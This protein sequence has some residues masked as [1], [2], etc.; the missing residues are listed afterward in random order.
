M[1][2]SL[3]NLF[4][5]LGS[6]LLVAACGGDHAGG[7]ETG[8]NGNSGQ[9][10]PVANAGTTQSVAAGSTVTLD[11]S[12]S[13][14]PSGTLGYQW[15]LV[16]KPAE[17]TAELQGATSAR[18]SFVADKVGRYEADLV[19]SNGSASSDHARVVVM[20]G[21][22]DP[23]ADG[24]TTLM[25]ELVD[26]WVQLD[27]SYS[28]PPAGGDPSGL[29]YQW[30]VTDPKGAAVQLFDSKSARP[31]F[32]PATD[33]LYLAKL[34][35]LYGARSS[36]EFVISVNVTKA[37]TQPVSHVGG[38]NGKYAGV[39]G[40][41]VQLDGSQSSDADGDAL[42]YTWTLV[43]YPDINNGKYMPYS[44]ARLENAD[45]A[46][47]TFHADRAGIYSVQLHV[48]DG[49]ARSQARTATVT[50][51][52]PEGAENTPPVAHLREYYPLN[53]AEM[54]V[55]GY[56]YF[57][58][59]SYDLD[60]DKLSYKWE[61]GETPVGFNKTDLSG[62][63]NSASV[64]FIPTVDG[65]PTGTPVEGY[66]TIYLTVNDGQMDSQRATQ[67]IHVRTGANKRPTASVKTDFPAVMVGSE[68]WFDGSTSSD[69]NDGTL[70]L[71]YQWRWVTRPKGSAAEFSAPTAA[72][73]SFVPDVAGAFT[74][75]LIVTD[76]DGTPSKESEWTAMPVT[77]TIMAKKIN[78]KP[79]VRFLGVNYNALTGTSP[80]L[81]SDT[82]LYVYTLGKDATGSCQT[83]DA[84]RRGS[85]DNFTVSARAHDP[86]G[87]TLFYDLTLEQPA[88]SDFQRSYTGQVGAGGN[89]GVQLC[90]FRIPGDYKFT[91]QV[92][93]SFEL[94]EPQTLT[95][96][97]EPQPADFST[98][99]LEHA[100]PA[101]DW[102]PQ[103]GEAGREG[104]NVLYR[105]DQGNYTQWE[106]AFTCK[107]SYEEYGQGGV[108]EYYRLTAVGRDYTI[109][110]V[111]RSVQ[112]FYPAADGQPA[113]TGDFPNSASYLPEF[114]NL[115]TVIRAGES[116]VFG[117]RLP[118]SPPRR[119]RQN[120]LSG[121]MYHYTWAFQVP[122]LLTQNSTGSDI[123]GRFTR[124]QRLDVPFLP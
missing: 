56:A 46:T 101:N 118:P 30:N 114:V 35:V 66:Y 54:S 9:G 42:S 88:G 26:G 21:N 113:Y 99:K 71:K 52:K 75:E 115:P 121:D 94:T 117:L 106:C 1:K 47:P 86:D 102:T 83:M 57:Y 34:V 73:T 103:L 77:G 63:A 123:T 87:D 6:A 10:R 104:F 41:G 51:T 91:L 89:I 23:I 74:A 98:L 11:G 58:S 24:P 53:E 8:G 15:T 32:I 5:G 48:F 60:D 124:S 29:V 22:K 62:R 109:K 110:E 116:V 67:T 12:L 79:V 96:R 65:K 84:S 55:W 25:N 76:N 61:W 14:T 59:D 27:A 97:V 111:E 68:A 119:A 100:S 39:R 81:D 13:T 3:R 33:G 45:S 38:E 72:R 40:Q 28:Q 108:M 70:G 37:N 7:L 90:D 31:G 69:P 82:G 95:V 2:I 112:L 20:A 105:L 17:S 16:D 49:V 4:A 18:P 120:T 64:S 78:N 122:E 50:L 43:P 36:S 107:P 80:G 44:N 85:F 92:S 19:V 93:D